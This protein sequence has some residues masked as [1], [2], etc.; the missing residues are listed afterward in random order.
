M[1]AGTCRDPWGQNSCTIQS[2]GVPCKQVQHSKWLCA[3][4]CP[5]MQLPSRCAAIMFFEVRAH[6]QW[7]AC[8]MLRGMCAQ[9]G[10]GVDAAAAH[11]I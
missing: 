9:A 11:L 5:S 10:G 2:S 4:S 7:L 1:E 8:I 6:V 3:C